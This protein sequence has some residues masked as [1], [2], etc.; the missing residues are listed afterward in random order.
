MTDGTAPEILHLYLI[1]YELT[2]HPDQQYDGLLSLFYD[3]LKATALFEVKNI[4]LVRSSQSA[5][6]LLAMIRKVLFTDERIVILPVSA[7]TSTSFATQGLEVDI[8]SL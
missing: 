6:S 4:W 3:Q 5:A 8:A 1:S 2:A 7:F